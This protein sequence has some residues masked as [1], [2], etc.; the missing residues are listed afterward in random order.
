MANIVE[1]DT[2]SP[3][4]RALLQRTQNKVGV[5]KVIAVAAT[6]KVRDHFVGV[7]G[8]MRNPFGKPAQFWKRMNRA[9]RHE[10]TSTHAAVIMPREVA[11]RFYGGTIRPTGG[12]RFLT[13]PAIAAAYRRSARSFPDLVLVLFKK[14]AGRGPAGALV[15]HG[16]NQSTIFYWLH[17]KVTQKADARVLPTSAQIADAVIPEVEAYVLRGSKPIT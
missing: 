10:A 9:T 3:A 4:L 7:A 15:Q 2:A 12:R 17:R 6:R 14:R 8:W 13:I 16:K 5:N 11:Q 1:I